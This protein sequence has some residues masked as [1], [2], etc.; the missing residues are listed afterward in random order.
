MINA[1]K[2]KEMHHLVSYVHQGSINDLPV[3]QHLIC[4]P[5]PLHLLQPGRALTESPVTVFAKH[6]KNRC[7]ESILWL[8]LQSSGHQ[9]QTVCEGQSDTAP[10]DVAGEA[11]VVRAT[12]SENGQE[13]GWSRLLFRNKHLQLCGQVTLW[14]PVG[15]SL[16]LGS[17]DTTIPAASLSWGC[18]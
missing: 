18:A 8:L 5:T 11:T 2:V 15:A 17:L 7:Q 13:P 1:F 14:L 12:E 3:P 4:L 10:R 16:F 6:C 9:L